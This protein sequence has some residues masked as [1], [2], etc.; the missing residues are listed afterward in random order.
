MNTG[1]KQVK[2]ASWWLLL[3]GVLAVL[4]L[5]AHYFRQS[6]DGMVVFCLACLGLLLRRITW[7][8]LALAGVL[9]FGA[10]EWVVTAQRLVGMRLAMGKPFVRGAGIL[11]GVAV[12]TLLAGVLCWRYAKAIQGRKEQGSL[13]AKGAAPHAYISAVQAVAFLGT[14]FLLGWLR[15]RLPNLVPLLA[16]R[17]FP[18]MGMVQVAGAAWY[19]AWV[20]G[21]LCQPAKAGRVRRRLWW[22]FCS[23]FFAQFALGLAGFSTF[24]M[25]GALHLP[26][27]GMI[28]FGPIFRGGGLFMVFLLLFSLMLLGSAWCS[29]LCYFG[30]WDALA[31]NKQRIQP[32]SLFWQRAVRFGRPVVGLLGVAV[33]LGLR[34]LGVEAYVAAMAGVLFGVVG[35]GITLLFSRRYGL[36]LHCTAYCPIGLIANVVGRVSFWRVRVVPE[37]CT[38]CGV[39]E[40]VCRYAALSPVERANGRSGF[41]CSLCRDCLGACPHGAL[42][43]GCFGLTHELA[44]AL[45]VVLVTVLHVVFLCTARV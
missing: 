36:M 34:V 6:D 40:R 22:L 32:L 15:W 24:L 7:G 3:P 20:A 4:L 11:A 9:G 8:A 5:G 45:F 14:A 39:C 16:D 13:H 17:F 19:A 42:R 28:L 37:R 12:F 23:V 18:G 43:L 10:W 21:L 26:I 35:L 38:G 44:T 29:H 25:T 27:P 30:G 2:K 41:R 1:P 31:T 33:A